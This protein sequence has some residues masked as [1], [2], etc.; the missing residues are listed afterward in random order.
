FRRMDDYAPT[1]DDFRFIELIQSQF[2]QSVTGLPQSPAFLAS[3]PATDARLYWNSIYQNYPNPGFTVCAEGHLVTEPP[4]QL[5]A[6]GGV[7][8]ATVVEAFG[9][10]PR[11]VLI[12][13]ATSGLF[14]ASLRE[15]VAGITAGDPTVQVSAYGSFSYNAAAVTD[16][17]E[18][19]LAGNLGLR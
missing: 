3:P 16:W 17:T 10:G 18:G 15:D 8:S 11:P 14:F 5:S 7:L 13:S 1:G 2:A 12:T 6:S 19:V 4:P 9:C